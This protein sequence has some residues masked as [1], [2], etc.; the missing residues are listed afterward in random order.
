MLSE[1]NYQTYKKFLIAEQE[2]LL[3][4]LNYDKEKVKDLFKQDDIVGD[5]I[6]HANNLYQKNRAIS[7]AEREKQKLSDI[8]DALVRIEKKTFGV[9]TRCGK[10]ITKKRL[11][12]IPWARLCISNDCAKIPN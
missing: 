9:C 5:V 2:K 11:K 3:M 6:D 4:Q 8:K 7:V 1:K 12:A 10:A